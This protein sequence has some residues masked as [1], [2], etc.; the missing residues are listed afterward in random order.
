MCKAFSCIV[1]KSGK[2]FWKVGLDEHGKIAELVKPAQKG[3]DMA[4]IEITPQNK[5][6][7]KALLG[8][9]TWVLTVDEEDTPKWFKKKHELACW[10]AQKLWAKQLKLKINLQEALNQ[11]HPFKIAPPKITAKHIGL[12]KEWASVRDSVS[13]S[14]GDS[15]WD[16]VRDS[17][18]DSVGASVGDS[19]WDSVGAS[20]RA[21]VRASVGNSVW[22]SVGDSVWDS[23]WAYTGSLFA[24]KRSEWQGTEKI[25]T[26][27]YPFQP[28]VTLWK[29]GLVPSF[30]G[31]VWRLHG[32]KDGKVLFEITKEKLMEGK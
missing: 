5:N 27:G 30:D 4:K 29:M 7:V 6:Y 11:I 8:K 2:V 18:R 31:K 22:D 26:K 13:N 10:K 1:V 19:V 28:A 3:S 32:G 24:L 12:L 16:S 15:V 23:V 25:K 9:E 14:V 21:S 17:V 20:V